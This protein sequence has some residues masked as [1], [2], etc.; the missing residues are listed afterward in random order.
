[1]E[2]MSVTLLEN[3]FERSHLLRDDLES[4]VHVLFY[5][6]FRYRP[7]VMGDNGDLANSFHFAFDH[8]EY[9]EDGRST[10][11]SSRK[12]I[13]RNVI[14]TSSHLWK[15]RLPNSLVSPMNSLRNRFA[16]LYKERYHKEICDSLEQNSQI[17]V[18]HQTKIVRALEQI[19]ANRIATEKTLCGA[20]PIVDKFFRYLYNDDWSP[21]DGAIDQLNGCQDI[22][23]CCLRCR[24]QLTTTEDWSD[25]D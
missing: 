13:L 24:S 9:E 15:S 10:G 6:V 16:L 5:Y 8:V 23:A 18:P 3:P 21:D 4:L 7:T 19:E 1:M 25:D 2:Y 11:G 17:P 22:L 14:L 20:R 12:L